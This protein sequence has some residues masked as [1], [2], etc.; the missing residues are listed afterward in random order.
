MVGAT[1]LEPVTSRFQ[2][3]RATNCATPR[4]DAYR[5]CTCL[6][7]F[8]G[9]CLSCSANAPCGSPGKIRTC[10]MSVNSRLFYR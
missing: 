5:S 2:T 4:G 8:A 7:D 3:A 6:R 1:G 9:L 10:D